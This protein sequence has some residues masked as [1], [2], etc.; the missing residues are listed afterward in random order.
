[1]AAGRISNGFTVK[2][3]RDAT[4]RDLGM[5]PATVDFRIVA[6]QFFASRRVQCHHDAA[7]RRQVELALNQDRVGFEGE[8]F[9]VAF[10]EFASTVAPDLLELRDVGLCDLLQRRILHAVLAATVVI[11]LSQILFL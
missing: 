7:T 6:P 9:P 3:R 1:M 2:P 5:W 8:R 11:P 4:I 10:T